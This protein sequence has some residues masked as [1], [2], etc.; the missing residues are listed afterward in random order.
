MILCWRAAQRLLRLGSS[1]NMSARGI[2]TERPAR[3]TI[4]SA[5]R[6]SLAACLRKWTLYFRITASLSKNVRPSAAWPSRYRRPRD[7][8]G[9]AAPC[10]PT[11]YCQY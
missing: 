9:D 1:M 2:V 7:T 10:P 3:S 8:A 4:L 6:R 5:R 11:L